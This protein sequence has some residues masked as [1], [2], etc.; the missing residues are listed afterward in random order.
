MFVWPGRVDWAQSQIT[1][2]PEPEAG[3]SLWLAASRMARRTDE[4]W[5]NSEFLLCTVQGLVA[6]STR[7]V[8]PKTASISLNAENLGGNE[9]K[10]RKGDVLGIRCFARWDKTP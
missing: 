9:G 3:P 4:V 1:L 2:A 7:T 6:S 5:A 8:S 10:G